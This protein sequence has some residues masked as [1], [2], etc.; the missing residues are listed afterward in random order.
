MNESEQYKGQDRYII[1]RFIR[2]GQTIERVYDEKINSS[3]E[4]IIHPDGK[5]EA[6][7]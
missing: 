4:Y 3:S 5:R 7:C 6:R 1:T 2:K